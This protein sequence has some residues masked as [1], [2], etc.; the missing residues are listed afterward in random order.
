MEP[1]ELFVKMKESAQTRQCTYA[2]VGEKSRRH[3]KY[4]EAVCFIFVSDVPFFRC[5]LPYL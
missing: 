2:V 1:L 3:S 4:G 5:N